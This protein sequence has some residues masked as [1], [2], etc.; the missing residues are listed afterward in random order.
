MRI[1]EESP[2]RR[3]MMGDAGPLQLAL[4][5]DLNMRRNIVDHDIAE[6]LVLPVE[7][8]KKLC[9][10]TPISIQGARC[11]APVL[12]PVPQKSIHLQSKRLL[13]LRLMK[14]SEQSEPLRGMKHELPLASVK[15]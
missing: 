10:V 6:G 13:L 11:Q 12:L 14:P 5:D 8:N 1:A 4:G 7:A 15:T 2:Q 9:E 3:D